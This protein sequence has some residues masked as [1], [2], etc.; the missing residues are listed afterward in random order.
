MWLRLNEIFPF[1]IAQIGGQVYIFKVGAVSYEYKIARAVRS[2]RSFTRPV[3]PLMK[4]PSQCS[5]IIIIDAPQWFLI[6]RII[7]E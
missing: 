5:F 2:M 1:Q 6:A 7:V 4:N 3:T